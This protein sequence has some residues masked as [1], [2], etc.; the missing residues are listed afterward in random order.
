MGT[1]LYRLRDGKIK[2]AFS[3]S[4]RYGFL[5][6]AKFNLK[7]VTV[8]LV[9]SS[10][11]RRWDSLMDQNHYLGF[12]GFAGRGLRYVA[13]YRG[14]WLALAGWQ[15]GVFRCRPRDRWL[16]WKK[17][18]QFRRLHLIANNT[19]F[20]LLTE[21][22]EVRNLG[23]CVMAKM[24]RRLSADWQRTWGH[25]L[26]LA[27]T[28][29]DPR[30]FSGT[31][32]RAGN[33]RAAGQ[34]KGYA[35]SNGRYTAR[36][37]KRKERYVYPLRPQACSRLRNRQ[38][39]PSWG[40]QVQRVETSP[41]QLKSLVQ[42]L[43]EM[44]DFRRAQGRKHRLEMVLAICILARLAGKVGPLATSRYAQKMT[45]NQL[46]TLGAI[47]RVMTETDPEALQAVTHRWVTAQLTRQ[48][49]EALAADGKRINGA[50]RNSNEHFETVILVRHQDAV[51][52]AVRICRDQ[53]GEQAAMAALLEDVDIRGAVITIDALHTNRVMADAIVLVNGAHFLFT[54]KENNPELS[55]FL[56]SLDWDRV[57]QDRFTENPEKGHGRIDQRSIQTYEPLPGAV[58]LP[59]VLQVFRIIRHRH[60]WNGEPDT[61]EYAYG[62]TSL[63]REAADAQRLVSLNRGHGTVE[64]GNHRRRDGIFGED[65]CLMRT[66]H[67]PTNNALFNNLALA[68]ILQSGYPNLAEATDDFQTNRYQGMRAVT[69]TTPFK[70]PKKR[71]KKS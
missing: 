54:V 60:H 48:P 5:R 64:N 41:K 49:L 51:P 62:V 36:H 10:E 69:K 35:R 52:I 12:K 21:L 45:Q 61:V 13:E 57:A 43:A 68:I 65:D 2:L 15:S 9:K 17:R 56:T 50:N 42:L 53:G 55:Q 71:P 29:V 6:D 63:P 8:R 37:N 20:L 46:R 16:G 47:H 7:R 30:Y 66:R 70:R 14:R 44:A 4:G 33:W 24:L 3:L 19:R 32:Y 67:G 25:P 38:D 11:R 23:S 27:E 22:G 59:H 39:D 26:E 34:S 58:T 40:P 18:E 1:K 28:F 31:I